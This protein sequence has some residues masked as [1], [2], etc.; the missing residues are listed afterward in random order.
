MSTRARERV[1]QEGAVVVATSG[2]YA[3]SP[4]APAQLLG[5]V[6]RPFSRPLRR[7]PPR[8]SWR[9]PHTAARRP[10]PARASSGSRGRIVAPRGARVHAVPAGA[11]DWMA[12]ISFVLGRDREP[13]AIH[14]LAR[15][16]RSS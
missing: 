9:A 14:W 13:W 7:A 6:S 8:T 3:P 4:R 5:D 11:R 16:L 12:R 10:R 1:I 2:L 15:E